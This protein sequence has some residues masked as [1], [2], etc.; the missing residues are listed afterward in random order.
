MAKPNQKSVD[1][2]SIRHGGKRRAFAGLVEEDDIAVGV[3][4][5]RLAPHPRLVARA[6]LEGDPV[7]RKLFDPLVEVVA[8][9]IDGGRRD[10]LS[11]G[12]I[13]TEK[14]APPAVSNRA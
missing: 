12:S 6:M 3:A 4:Q 8:F 1:Q 14:V 9:E 7:A 11:S 13:W 5:P 2:S 10:D